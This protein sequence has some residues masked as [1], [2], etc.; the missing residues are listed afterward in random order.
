MNTDK[1]PEES[2]DRQGPLASGL[3]SGLRF[4]LGAGILGA[5][6]IVL[7]C[8]G[9]AFLLANVFGLDLSQPASRTLAVELTVEGDGCQVTRTELETEPLPELRWFVTNLDG[10]P[11]DTQPAGEELSFRYSE[12]GVFEIT[13]QANMDGE[14]EDISNGVRVFCEPEDQE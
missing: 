7:V 9:G 5:L 13:L 11:V 4:G 6:M 12:Y 8:L 3:W 14:F 10:V 1:P 2:S